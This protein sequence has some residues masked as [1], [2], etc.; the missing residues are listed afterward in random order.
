[1]DPAN[2]PEIK[3]AFEIIAIKQ[4]P[5]TYRDSY[6][7]T[8]QGARSTP[9]AVAAE[10]GRIRVVPNPYLVSSLFEEEYGVL[11]R[12]PIRQ[13]KFI[14]LPPACTITIFTLDGDKVKVIDHTN[15]EGVE[16]WDMK[17]DGG[18][19]IAPGIYIYLVKTE[20]A[21]KIDRFA[22]IK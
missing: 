18:R 15:G 22:V 5:A 8:T 12:E 10:L 7:F 14:H 21:E 20:S 19:V 4:K 1:V 9:Q 2:P 3:T 13:I 17:S 16:T 11:R 6:R